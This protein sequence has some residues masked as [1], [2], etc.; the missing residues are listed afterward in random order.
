M[1]HFKG[2]ENGEILPGLLSTAFALG[3]DLVEGL[4][5]DDIVFGWTGNDVLAGGAGADVLIGGLLTVIANIGS[6]EIA[7]SDTADYTTSDAGVVI[8]LSNKQDL[9]VTLLGLTIGL[10]DATLGMNGHADGDLLVGISNLTGSAFDD[11]LGGDASANFLVGGTGTDILYYFGSDAGVS[12]NLFTGAVDGGHATGDFISGF[13]NVFGSSFRDVIAGDLNHNTIIGAGGDDV[14]FGQGGDDVLRGG[15][16]NDRLLGGFGADVLDGG[17]GVDVVSYAGALRTGVSIDLAAR[18]GLTGEATGDTFIGISGAIGSNFAD[19]L[20]GFAGRNALFGGADDDTIDGRAGAD[21]LRGEAGD[22]TL[23]GGA[24]NDRMS[25]GTGNDVFVFS[26]GFGR[27]V[28]EDFQNGLDLLDFSD[29][30][31]VSDLS[32]LSLRTFR[33]NAVVDDGAGNVLVL[34]GMAGL[35]DAGDFVF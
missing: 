1:T 33:G 18:A 15:A 9:T 6:T 4:G 7:G 31:A 17:A 12:V 27:D 19:T 22:D 10:E 11:V 29:N 34:T 3:D 8:D 20:L 25:G 21:V 24:G 30:A 28:I 16:G 14:L 13:E 35:L 2:T 5:G 26:D 23:I 32:D